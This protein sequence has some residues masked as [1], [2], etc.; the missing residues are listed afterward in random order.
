M[1]EQLVYAGSGETRVLM[2]LIHCLLLSTTF[3]AM[4]VPQTDVTKH[5]HFD[6]AE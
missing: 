1:Q 3:V 6:A 5:R 4:C 2:T